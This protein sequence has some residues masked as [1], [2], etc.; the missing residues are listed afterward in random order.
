LLLLGDEHHAQQVVDSVHAATGLGR[1]AAVLLTATVLLQQE[2]NMEIMLL[3]EQI[4]ILLRILLTCMMIAACR[5]H[6][7][8]RWIQ[9]RCELRCCTCICVLV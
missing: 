7:Q 3:A 9:A 6:G 2:F 4:V 8:L 1:I 5:Q